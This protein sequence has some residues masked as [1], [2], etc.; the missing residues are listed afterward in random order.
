MKLY[1]IGEVIDPSLCEYIWLGNICDPLLNLPTKSV[2]KFNLPIAPNYEGLK[3]LVG[4]MKK[5]LGNNFIPA[6]GMFGGVLLAISFQ[7]VIKKLG[8]C[9]MVLATGG[10]SCGKTTTLKSILYVMGSYPLGK[11]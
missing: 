5:I 4:V 10:L 8:Y 7:T 11:N 9:P 6:L 1:C 3:K 2:S